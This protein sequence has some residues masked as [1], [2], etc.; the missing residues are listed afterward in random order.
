MRSACESFVRCCSHIRREASMAVLATRFSPCF[1]KPTELRKKKR[2]LQMSLF[3]SQIP[4]ELAWDRTQAS[5]GADRLRHYT[6]PTTAV[7]DKCTNHCALY[8]D[9]SILFPRLADLANIY[10]RTPVNLPNVCLVIVS[11]FPRL[12]YLVTQCT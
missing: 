6:V 8:E 4:H 2:L 1:L 5:G 12:V 3:P 9:P 7:F 10:T 11:S